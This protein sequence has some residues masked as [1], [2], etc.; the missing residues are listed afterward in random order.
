MVQLVAPGYIDVRKY[1]PNKGKSSCQKRDS[2]PGIK[3]GEMVDRVAEYVLE[4][5]NEKLAQ[6]RI[7]DICKTFGLNAS[8]LSR[9]FKDERET[10][11]CEFIQRVKIQRAILLLQQDQV[12]QRIDGDPKLN[13]LSINLLAA[14]L[15]YSSTEYFIRCFKKRMGVSPNKY[16]KYL[17]QDDAY[18]TTLTT[19]CPG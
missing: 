7:K 18:I 4:L 14:H 1:L 11:L 17:Y 3:P 15:G 5:D 2:R 9:K 6:I 12:R 16:R 13:K 19:R 8:F 10:V